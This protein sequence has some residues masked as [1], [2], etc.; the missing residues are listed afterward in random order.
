MSSN[1]FYFSSD[2]YKNPRHVSDSDILFEIL[3]CSLRYCSIHLSIVQEQPPRASFSVQ[4]RGSEY[5]E[6]VELR[7]R[8]VNIHT[9]GRIVL[10]KLEEKV[11]A[12]ER[13]GN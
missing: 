6:V 4:Q 13:G 2:I 5:R 10:S 12:S 3:T 8:H 11:K 7:V 1:H 9:A